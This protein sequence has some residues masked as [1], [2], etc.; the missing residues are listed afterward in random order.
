MKNNKLT[1]SELRNVIK[2]E[3]KF[4]LTKK[5]L[6]E[7]LDSKTLKRI[8]N[9]S[10]VSR[11]TMDGGHINPT[12]SEPFRIINPN[13]NDKV[14][15][16][17]VD[18]NTDVVS[19]TNPNDKSKTYIKLK[20]IY[21]L[22][23]TTDSPEYKEFLEA[24]KSNSLKPNFFS[25]DKSSHII[26]NHDETLKRLGLKSKYPNFSYTLDLEITHSSNVKINLDGVKGK[27]VVQ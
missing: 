24:R 22:Q 15:T 21:N 16:N 12:T 10:V 9:E 6:V 26:V 5:N 3:V 17:V 7:S 25:S 23:A 4:Q 11:V 13:P 19:P 8:L 27:K 18:V 14:T 2:E 1:L 20:Y